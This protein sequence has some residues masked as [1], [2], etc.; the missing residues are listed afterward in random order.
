MIVYKDV[1]TNDN[2]LMYYS[3]RLYGYLQSS[4]K[5][6]DIFSQF[7]ATQIMPNLYLGNIN[8]CYDKKELEK[9]N[10]KKVISVIA[11]FIPPYPDEFEYVVI[12]AMD[13]LNTKLEESFDL[14][15]DE[16]TKSLDN[17]DSILVHCV[18]GRSRSCS[19]ILAYLM[20]E[21]GMKIDDG[22]KLVKMKRPIVEP[23]AEFLKQLKNY[24]KKSSNQKE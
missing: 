20:R 19:I 8:S 12:N 3:Y 11:G 23:N 21:Y 24:E 18:A 10:I 6:Y 13:S 9:R 5:Y 17:E 4:L 7:E 16:I 2:L 15:C 22:L 1:E 14:A